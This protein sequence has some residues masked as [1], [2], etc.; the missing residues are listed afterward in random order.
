MLSD[1]SP[2][3]LTNLSHRTKT[4]TL[5][6]KRDQLL[7]DIGNYAYVEG[8]IMHTED[9][10][11]R[12]QVQDIAQDGNVDRT[13]RVL[14]LA[15]SEVVESTYP[16]SKR[17]VG[18]TTTQDNTLAIPSEYVLQMTVPDDFSQTSVDYMLHNI[19][20]FLVCRVV[21]DWMSITNPSSAEKWMLKQQEALTKVRQS[22]NMRV[23]RIRR[24]MAPF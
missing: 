16:Y 20:E 23:R 4:V 10:H 21:G 14:N 2:Y 11:D 12:H 9:E 5:T 15:F 3:N 18:D 6:F 1:Q 22:V 13:T 8:D 17:I 7:Y 19:H 24:T